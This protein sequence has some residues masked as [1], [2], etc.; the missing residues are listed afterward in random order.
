EGSHLRYAASNKAFGMNGTRT[1]RAGVPPGQPD[2]V[3]TDAELT[4]A[5]A[6]DLDVTFEQLVLAYQH[7]LFGFALR[8]CGSR[9]DAEE[10]AQDAFARAYRALAAYPPE[11]VLTLKLG[12]WLI[13]ITLNVV[14]NRVQRHRIATISLDEPVQDALPRDIA[15]DAREQ[16]EAL[17][18]SA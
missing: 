16:P 15:G 11:R 12:P 17:A 18:V 7:R 10:V 2:R 13:Q 9:Q 3:L 8:L 5:L 1:R 14:R 6:A 4:A